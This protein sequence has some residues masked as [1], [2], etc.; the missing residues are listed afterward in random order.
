M[1][2][3]FLGEKRSGK[4]TSADYLCE[5]N[6]IKLA[7]AEPLKEICKI[8]FFFNDE[9]LFGNAKEVID[10]FW[11]KTPRE[12]YQEIGTDIFR[13]DITKIFPH[14]KDDFWVI[15][16]G[17][18]LEY[19]EE[20]NIVISDVRYQNEIDQIHKL[21]GVVIKIIRPDLENNDSHKSEKGIDDLVGFDYTIIN[22]QTKKD[23]YNKINDV[24]RICQFKNTNII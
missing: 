17:R 16:M 11:K 8:L 24:F 6:F 7:Y 13:D 1:L 4:D 23:L 2:V 21:G 3:G 18:R 9:Q 14:I 5:S 12:I 20:K 22:N 10:P 19:L 15:H